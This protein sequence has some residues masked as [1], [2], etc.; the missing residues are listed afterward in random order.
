MIPTF[1]GHHKHYKLYVREEAALALA[2]A[3]L[4][5]QE[6]KKNRKTKIK[7]YFTL[8]ESNIQ[9]HDCYELLT[10]DLFHNTSISQLRER[11][12]HLCINALLLLLYGTTIGARI[13]SFKTCFR[14]VV[15][16]CT[17]A[18]YVYRRRKKITA[19][20]VYAISISTIGCCCCCCCC[21]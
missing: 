4:Q 2:W 21:E 11:M 8:Y 15:V 20:S 9:S 7:Y 10:M 13:A 6:K 18:W 12:L 17:T 19:R 5:R 3:T 14:F 1:I 16:I